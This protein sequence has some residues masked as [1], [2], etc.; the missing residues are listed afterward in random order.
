[1]MLH[2]GIGREEAHDQRK[3][4]SDWAIPGIAG[5]SPWRSDGRLSEGAD[6]RGHPFGKRSVVAEA[7]S[8][9]PGRSLR[10]K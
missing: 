4:T 5:L 1:M 8:R 7:D 9:S 2:G 3:G 10:R 6:T